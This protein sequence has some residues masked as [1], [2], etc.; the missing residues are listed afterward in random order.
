[1]ALAEAA[2]GPERLGADVNVATSLPTTRLLFSQTA[3]RAVVSMPAGRERNLVEAGR[4]YGVAVSLL[5]RVVPGRLAVSVNGVRALDLAT[6]TL[7]TDSES[8][9]LKLVEA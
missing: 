8:A 6:A 9:F 4:R 3:G 1:V 5:G 7:K 2:M